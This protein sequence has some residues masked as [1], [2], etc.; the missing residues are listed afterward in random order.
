MLKESEVQK[1]VMTYLVATGYLVVRVNSIVSVGSNKYKRSYRIENNG[2]SSGFPDVLAM[3]QGKCMLLEIKAGDGGTVSEKQK[4]FIELAGQ[5][6][7]D[8]HVI[9]DL[10]Q[11]IEIVEKN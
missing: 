9:S 11:V 7:V 8:V 6:G 10:E 1:Q 5:K 4:D 3:K 2:E